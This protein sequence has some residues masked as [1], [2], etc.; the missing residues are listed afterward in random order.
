MMDAPT[1]R[2]RVREMI[3]TGELPCDDLAGLWAGMGE[4][5]RCAACAE[6][7]GAAEVEYEVN[8]TSGKKVLLHQPCHTIWLQEC[9]P[10]KPAKPRKTR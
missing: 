5:K 4:G 10:D 3:T 2:R 1:I 8:L 7:I 9:G 6:L